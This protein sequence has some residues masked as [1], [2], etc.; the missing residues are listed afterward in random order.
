[1]DSSLSLCFGKVGW[2]AYPFLFTDSVLFSFIQSTTSTTPPAAA[3]TASNPQQQEECIDTPNF[4]DLYG[5]G[6]D[7]YELPENEAWC[8]AYGNDEKLRKHLMRIVVFVKVDCET[9]TREYVMWKVMNEISM[10]SRVLKQ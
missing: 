8:G 1:M 6:C 10:L 9:Y 7:L 4:L 5:G 2:Y 3:T